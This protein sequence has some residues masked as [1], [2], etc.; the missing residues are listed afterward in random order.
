MK[1]LIVSQYW[2]PEEGV[3]QRRWTW[4]SELLVTEGH[5]LM[6][7]APP[8]NHL[9]KR[10]WKNWINSKGYRSHR[11]AS[12]GPSGELIVRSGYVPAYGSLTMKAL[13]QATVAIGAIGAIYK[14]RGPIGSWTPD[15]VVGTV[16]ALPT[17][18]VAYLAAKKF[19]IPYVI[20]LRDAWPDLLAQS[21]KWNAGLDK[22]SI[23]EKLLNFGLT[24][25]IVAT[26]ERVL[27]SIINGARSL[28][29]TSE[30]LGD[31]FRRQF[32]VEHD[33][34]RVVTVRN[35]FP[36]GGLLNSHT[37]GHKIM[38]PH[39]S[40]RVLYAGT[41][42]RA[43]DL[44]NAVKAVHLARFRGVPVEMKIVGSGDAL[45]AVKNYSS[46]LGTAITFHDRVT[47]NEMNGFYD[48]ADTA[49]VHLTDWEPLQRAVPSKTYEVME[50][51]LHITAVANGETSELVDSLQ[52]G[53]S[54][55]PSNPQDLAELWELLFQ[56]PELL[57]PSKYARDWVEQQRQDTRQLLQKV[58]KWCA[59]AK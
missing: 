22:K 44:K 19:G 12:L 23:R 34:P 36:R 10:S 17:A 58:T 32:G 21:D 1:I 9:R 41:V 14:R 47:L 46:S 56:D 52:A 31:A 29:V 59:D 24:D 42:G 57:V 4:L 55:P 33:D 26:A 6:V 39:V 49:L 8:S 51:G 27:N 50:R 11:E 40:L 38:E 45:Q 30:H 37:E 35:V 7:V 28:V 16:P 18:L 15:L 43:Q 48:W 20:D 13:N 5:E 25:L 54:V 53:H 3:P 2:F